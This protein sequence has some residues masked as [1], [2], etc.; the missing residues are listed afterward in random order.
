MHAAR[1]GDHRHVGGQEEPGNHDP[2]QRGVGG[3]RHPRLG[4]PG[5]PHLLAELR[6]VTHFARRDA[7]AHHLAAF[8]EHGAAGVANG[9]ARCGE[10]RGRHLLVARPRGPLRSVEQLHLGGAHNHRQRK[11]REGG[12][13]Q[14]RAVSERRHGAIAAT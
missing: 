6:R 10:R 2:L 9:A 1:R 5:A 7:Q 8:N 3:A 12:V 11:E 4:D 14:A 13:D